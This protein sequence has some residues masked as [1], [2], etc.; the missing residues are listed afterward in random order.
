MSETLARGGPLA[1]GSRLLPTDLGRKG[2]NVLGA[3]RV[4]EVR[5]TGPLDPDAVEGAPVWDEADLRSDA[6]SGPPCHF[7]GYSLWCVLT[8]RDSHCH[9]HRRDGSLF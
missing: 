6:G 4:A 8:G 2:K 1:A 3:G 7:Q 9:S 5:E